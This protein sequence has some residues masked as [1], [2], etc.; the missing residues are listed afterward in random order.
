MR[1]KPKPTRS[2][3]NPGPVSRAH[4]MQTRLWAISLDALYGTDGA[5]IEDPTPLLTVFVDANE[6]AAHERPSRCDG[7]RRS[8]GW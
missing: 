5:S 6:A 1:S 7:C 4:G 2:P 8:A 3:Q